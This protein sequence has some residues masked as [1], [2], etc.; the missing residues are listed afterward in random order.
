MR[1]VARN[2]RCRYGE[3]DLIAR[4]REVTAFIEVKT[5]TGP[6]FG[7]PSESV[8]F[9]KQ[10]RIRTVALSWLTQQDGPW[11][12]VRFDVVAVVLRRGYRP[13]IDHLQGV[14]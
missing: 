4:D 8:T 12:T 5:R 14:F 10:R 9:A 2:W 1:I 3:L 11:L 13:V 7:A 6:G